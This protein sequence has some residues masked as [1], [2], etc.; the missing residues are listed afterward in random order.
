M[1]SPVTW[2]RQMVGT[3]STASCREVGRVLQSYLDHE[4]DE[5]AARRVARHL[6]DCRRCGLEASTYAE[7]KAALARRADPVPE[8][9]VERLRQFGAQLT[10]EADGTGPDAG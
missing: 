4:L 5:V 10:D 2:W 6:D 9:T 7:V 1:N 8:D 3:R